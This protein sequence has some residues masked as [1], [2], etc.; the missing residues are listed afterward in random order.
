MKKNI[1]PVIEEIYPKIYRIRLPLP[2]K[3]P[4]PVNVYLFKGRFV[5][6]IDTG[7][8]K[9]VNI[10]KEALGLA[11]VSLSDI[12][13]VIVTH[14]HGDHYGAARKILEF[15]GGRT[16]IAAHM[17][18]RSIIENGRSVPLEQYIKFFRLMGVPLLFRI[19]MIIV[20]YLYN[21][22][23]DNCPIHKFLSDG[24]IINLGDYQARVISTPGH[25]KG[26]I[27]LYLEKENI[28]FPGD[29]ILAHITPNA[30]VMLDND[31]DLPL[32]MSQIE[33]YDSLAKIEKISPRMVFPAHG[34]PIIDIGKI[35]NT[36]RDQFSRRQRKIRA[37]LEKGEQTAYRISRIL[38]PNIGGARLFME[39]FLIVSEA[40]THL[41]VLEKKGVVAS[42]I[43]K[44]SVHFKLS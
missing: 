23:A 39:T 8:N 14:G 30:F 9:T 17:E 19:S 24:D 10:L 41:Q 37:I 4:G 1:K 13:N 44:G 20:N 21:S 43:K 29:H 11:G 34:E 31:F 3:G 35:I 2:V 40:Y 22:M 16:R 33:F 32:R 18:E 38:F 12:E 36:F 28:L 7:T 25:S 27:S 42:A 5:S 15:S 26:A 6:L